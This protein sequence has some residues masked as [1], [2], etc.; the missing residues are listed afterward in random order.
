MAHRHVWMEE[1]DGFPARGVVVAFLSM[2]SLGL[3]IRFGRRFGRK[4]G[5]AHNTPR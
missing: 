5:P 4:L 2:E 1:M 3:P